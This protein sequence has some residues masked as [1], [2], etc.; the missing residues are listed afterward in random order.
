V[1]IITSHFGEIVA[2]FTFYV[3]TNS[4]SLTPAFLVAMLSTLPQIIFPL[5]ISADGMPEGAASAAKPT[6]GS[7]CRSV[8]DGLRYILSH[9]LLPGL[10]ALDWGMTAVSYYRELFPLFVAELFTGGRLGL[11]ARGAM[12]ALTVANYLGGISGG[13]FTFT[14]AGMPHK[15]RLVMYATIAYGMTCLLFGATTLLTVGLAATALCGAAD[16]VGATMRSTV[17]MMS[18]PDHMRGRARSGHSL[19]AN[20]ANS[21]GQIYVAAMAGWIGCGPTMLLGGVLTFGF[22]GLAVWRIPALMTYRDDQVAPVG[23]EVEGL[24]MKVL[25]AAE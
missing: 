11:N 3:L 25:Q 4:R 21:V 8:Y 13:V 6:M 17:V 14:M 2:P 23:K 7:R 20:A 1:N 12:S 22:T 15:G 5:L 10:Y 24:E 9:P 16:A 19:A 18:T